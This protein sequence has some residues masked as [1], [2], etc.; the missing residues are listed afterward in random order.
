MELSKQTWPVGQIA[1]G[2]YD[3]LRREIGSTCGFGADFNTWNHERQGLVDSCIQSG[4]KRFYFPPPA[5][6]TEQRHQWSFL[7]PTVTVTTAS[8]IPRAR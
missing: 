5:S 4:L 3:W 7:M 8:A 2:T 1:Y 6:Q